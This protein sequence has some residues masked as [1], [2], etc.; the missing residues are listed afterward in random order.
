[1]RVIS[2]VGLGFGCKRWSYSVLTFPPFFAS[3]KKVKTM[4]AKK[5]YHQKVSRVS[6]RTSSVMASLSSSK[7]KFLFSCDVES[8][9][10]RDLLA[11]DHLDG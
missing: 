4:D 3:S 5:Q 9:Q 6:S 11:V 7:F 2:M 8:K 1:M 10:P